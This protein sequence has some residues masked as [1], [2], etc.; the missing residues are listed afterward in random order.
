M[1]DLFTVWPSRTH[2]RQLRVLES[3]VQ[4]LGASHRPQVA[5]A[6]AGG[7]GRVPLGSRDL[8]NGEGGGLGRPPRQPSDL[9]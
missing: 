5:F 6:A 8:R 3:T 2:G 9:A 1:L 7:T 4:V